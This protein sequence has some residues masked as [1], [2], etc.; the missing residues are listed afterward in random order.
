MQTGTPT[1]QPFV[2]TGFD[3]GN[4]LS[5]EIHSTGGLNYKISPNEKGVMFTQDKIPVASNAL[6]QSTQV[7]MEFRGS[8]TIDPGIPLDKMGLNPAQTTLTLTDK[9]GKHGTLSIG[10]LTATQSDYYVKWENNPVTLVSKSQVDSLI[11]NYS[12]DTLLVPT[13]V[14]G[15]TQTP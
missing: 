10:D 14:P 11:G 7:L 6:Y 9:N 15:V 1:L 4:I 12:P 5:E 8:T 2:I 3:L 13:P